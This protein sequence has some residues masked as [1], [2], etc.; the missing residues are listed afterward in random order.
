MIGIALAAASGVLL[1]FADAGKKHL[2]T[3]FSPVML[4]LLMFSFGIVTNFV[5]LNFHGLTPITWESVWLPALLCGLL[6]AVGELLFL[7]GLRGADLSIAMPL[8]AFLPV[9][10]SMLGYALFDEIPSLLG[11]LGAVTIVAGAYLLNVRLPLRENLLLPIT[12]I[13]TNKACLF[14]LISAFIGAILFVGQRYGVRHSSP[15]TFFTMTLV[16]DWFVFLG[17]VAWSGQFRVKQALTGKLALTLCGTG[18]AWAIGLTCLYASYNYTLAVYA[19]SAMQ[20]QTLL[21]ITL[22]ALLFREQR[23]VQRL[24]AGGVIVAGVIMISWAAKF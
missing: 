23:Y 9:F 11:G 7:Y 4:I 17:L 15:V 10:S 2:T 5:Y 18:I 24:I 3:A 20:I 22:G 21:S 16:V 8:M 6:A 1:S 19:G 13:L 12:H 14:I